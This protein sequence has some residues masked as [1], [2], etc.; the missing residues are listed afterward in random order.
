MFV[1]FPRKIYWTDR[2]NPAKI[3]SAN[4]D[5]SSRKVLV[6]NNIIWPNGIAI[7]YPNSR[8]YWVDTKK[9]TIETVDMQG[10]DRHVVRQFNSMLF[11]CAS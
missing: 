10:S 1:S 7:D 5:G 6:E 9:Q 2:G 3:E 4:L 11:M 8:I